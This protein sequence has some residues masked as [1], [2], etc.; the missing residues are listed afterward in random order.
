MSRKHHGV[1]IR[2]T[3]LITLIFSF[4]ALTAGIYFVGLIY[5][6]DRFFPGTQINGY[7]AG[8]K[9]EAQ[10][11][12][13][14]TKQAK[15]YALAIHT[16]NNGVEGIT[17]EDVG[18]YYASD[19]SVP[20]ILE[21]Q[22]KR[23][24]FLALTERPVFE[25]PNSVY[26]DEELFDNAL[27]NLHCLQKENMVAPVDAQ[28]KDNGEKYYI[29]PES[30]GNTLDEEK[31]R[32]VI[33]EAILHEVQEIDLEEEGCYLK[34]AVYRDDPILTANC[35]QLNHY[36]EVVVTY[37][38]A[39]RKERVDYKLISTWLA[40]N[41]NG[42]YELDPDRVAAYIENLAQ[43]YNT[44]GTVREFRTYD[45]SKI[46]VGGGDYGWVIDQAAETR[47][48]VSLIEEGALVVRE[49]EYSQTAKSR[50]T[51]DIGYTYVEIDIANQR[52]VYYDEGYPLID[53][54]VVTGYPY[55]AGTQTPTGVYSIQRKESPAYL[56]R[57]G[58]GA[59]PTWWMPFYQD[60]GLHDSTWRVEYGGDQFILNGTIGCVNVPPDAMRSL[61][62]VVDVGTPVV[63]Y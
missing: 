4:L 2:R 1:S 51:N 56:E 14:L 45:T 20:K 30:E 54:S 8:F 49:P 29:E 35:D 62:G 44:V 17:A 48:L 38:F 32:S 42:I 31:V 50:D 10:V 41:Q 13:Y 21:S 60:L 63:I 6:E 39:D 52:L 61:Y 58:L 55:D 15:K 3:I 57:N 19:G 22:D 7:R 34:P 53:T 18:L 37:D 25:I 46:N 16:M 11:E 33:R 59:S 47:A 36:R 28:M 43:K 5:F 26:Y 24:W 9:T 40:Q 27:L 12:N 23:K